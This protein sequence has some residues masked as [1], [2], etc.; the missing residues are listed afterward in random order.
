MIVNMESLRGALVYTLVAYDMVEN[1]GELNETLAA[2]VW[3]VAESDHLELANVLRNVGLDSATYTSRFARLGK[4]WHYQGMSG[5]QTI[6]L[7]AGWEKGAPCE[8]AIPGQ[9]EGGDAVWLPLLHIG[10]GDIVG[11]V[12]PGEYT[13]VCVVVNVP[14]PPQHIVIEAV[15]KYHR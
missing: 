14:L 15:R 7:M 4:L 2:P 12:Q 10:T 13:G 1:M 8:W 6:A 11:S 9:T 5:Q 3:Q